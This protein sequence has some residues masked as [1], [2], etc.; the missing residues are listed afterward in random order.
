VEATGRLTTARLR[1]GRGLLAAVAAIAIFLGGIAMF[2]DRLLYFPA[3]ASLADLPKDLQPWPSATEFRGLIA[4]PPGGAQR[5]TILVFHGNAGHAGHR[6]PYAE[7][8][9]RLGLRVILAEYPGYGPRDG[10]LGQA[11]LV[12][13]ATRTLEL[14]ASHFG[15]PLVVLGESLGAAVAAAAGARKAPAISGL[16]LITPWDRLENVAS[17]HYPWLPVRWLLRDRYDTA[18]ILRHAGLPI[19]IVIAEQDEIVPAR[20]GRAL[21]EAVGAAHP[22]VVV[23]AAGHND[24]LGRVDDEWWRRTLAPL[25]PPTGGEGTMA[26]PPR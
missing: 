20:L 26:Q 1:P 8:L 23:P 21:H 19:V 12:D 15:K 14:A 2:Q 7:A 5:G 25:L 18:E 13:D 11:S 10:A 24:W 3:R 16:L 4:E 17:H 9:Q 6:R 22:L